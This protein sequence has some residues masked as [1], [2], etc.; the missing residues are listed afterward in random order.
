MSVF[1]VVRRVAVSGL[2]LLVACV[3][4]YS[5]APSPHPVAVA[6][7]A[8]HPTALVLRVGQ[9]QQLIAVVTDADG[10]QLRDR[11][12]TWATDSPD[13]AGVSDGGLVRA[14]GLG[15]VTITVTCE[16]KTFGLAGTVV[17][18]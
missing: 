7:V 4:G 14:N 5:S 3:D 12:V 8:A 11:V 9:S 13:V 16:G 18:D 10:H 15:Y 17:E 6:S 2:I 1:R